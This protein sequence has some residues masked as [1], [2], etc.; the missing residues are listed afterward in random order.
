MD[1]E[2]VELG[3]K[4]RREVLGDKYVDAAD[5]NLDSDDFIRPFRAA[6]RKLK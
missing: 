5:K 1:K 6:A 2:R 3:R 4:I